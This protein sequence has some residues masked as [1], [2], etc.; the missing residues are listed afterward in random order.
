MGQ[1][2]LVDKLPIHKNLLAAAK[3]PIDLVDHFAAD[4]RAKKQVPAAYT[5][6]KLAKRSP[7]PASVKI[8][9]L[10][11]VSVTGI[12]NDCHCQYKAKED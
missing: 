8:L 5:T 10:S 12:Q 1:Q 4:M 6:L 3:C 7:A 11:L 2:E 9:Y